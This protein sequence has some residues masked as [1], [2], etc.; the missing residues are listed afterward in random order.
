M[1]CTSFTH[2]FV[3]F[4]T[5]FARAHPLLRRRV[6][7]VARICVVAAALVWIVYLALQPVY[8]PVFEM[9][10]KHRGLYT[11][12]LSGVKGQTFVAP[13][14]ELSRMDIWLR[15]DVEPG[16][17]VA[18]T[19]TLYRGMDLG[20]EVASQV[21]IV[22]ES[23]DELR[24][25]VLFDPALISK[26][27]RLYLRLR[28]VL[29]SPDTHLFFAYIREDVYPEGELREVDRIEVVGQDLRF[30]L[31]RNPLLPKPLAWAEAPIARAIEAATKSDGPPPWTVALTMTVIG[32]LASAII[33]A[34]AVLAWPKLVDG[35][36]YAD[37]LGGV[38]V[39]IAV[40]LAI[41]AWG[42]APIGKL[43]VLLS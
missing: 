7:R 28:S 18:I 12:A 13:S 23:R 8:V 19:F 25:R 3:T 1:G 6:G 35:S 29:S 9:S 5:E 10:R 31:Y 36:G 15:T 14:G 40:V 21:I 2:S 27:D 24:A 41:A 32:L 43:V 4:W 26:G 17:E 22:R 37:A 30:E 39:L 20:E 11:Q 42:E 38:I 34:S 33:F 16:G